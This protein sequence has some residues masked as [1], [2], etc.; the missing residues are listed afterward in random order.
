M[1][2]N[3]AKR[4]PLEADGKDLARMEKEDCIDI[5]GH[6]LGVS[7]F[8]ELQPLKA[9]GALWSAHRLLELLTPSC[10]HLRPSFGA[11]QWCVFPRLLCSDLCT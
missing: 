4:F 6:I 8:R 7:L 2:D 5:L 1:A 3:D 9:K 11:T 10:S